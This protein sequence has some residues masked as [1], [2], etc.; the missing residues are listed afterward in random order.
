MVL[1]LETQLTNY[2]V[3]KHSVGVETCSSRPSGT[4][5]SLSEPTADM[6]FKQLETS[7]CVCI[8]I[9]FP[10]EPVYEC[11]LHEVHMYCAILHSH[12]LKSKKHLHFLKLHQRMIILN[13]ILCLPYMDA[14][15]LKLKQIP[16]LTMHNICHQN[17]MLHSFIIFHFL[18]VN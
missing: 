12:H 13:L 2:L 17:N 1:N 5:C 8:D 4:D 3:T 11:S 9:S 15:S 10:S 14:R 18:K 7:S 6:T 16:G